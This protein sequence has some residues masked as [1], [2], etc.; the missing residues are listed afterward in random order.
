MAAGW[1]SNKAPQ[2]L[3]S[4]PQGAE[5]GHILSSGQDVPGEEL[6]VLAQRGQQGPPVAR[7]SRFHGGGLIG[8]L[9][10]SLYLV[11]CTVPFTVT[12]TVPLPSSTGS[13]SLLDTMALCRAIGAEA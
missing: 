5:P 12:V 4:C 3:R 6:G 10:R 9:L 13:A 2:S 11:I 7:Q 8:R 1:L